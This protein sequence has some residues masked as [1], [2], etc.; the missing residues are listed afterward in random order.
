[1]HLILKLEALD[2]TLMGTTPY[3]NH[4]NE[5]D[6]YRLADQVA[7]ANRQTLTIADLGELT[8]RSHCFL[9][10]PR[11]PPSLHSGLSSCTPSA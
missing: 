5:Q 10:E 7:G 6:F 8:E 4:V 9:G 2:A 3:G 11:V 1:M